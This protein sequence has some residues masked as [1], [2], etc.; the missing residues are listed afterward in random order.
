[1]PGPSREPERR[2]RPL[3]QNE[4]TFIEALA[5]WKARGDYERACQDRAPTFGV[6]FNEMEG[7]QIID[8]T[9]N[10]YERLD[11]HSTRSK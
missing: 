3:N 4:R 11:P 6:E 2:T 10:E 5:R 8:L 7:M 9:E 1:M